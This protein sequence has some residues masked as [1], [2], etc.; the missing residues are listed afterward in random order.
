M[1]PTPPTAVICA[2][3]TLGLVLDELATSAG[4]EVTALVSRGVD[5]AVEAA[6][7]RGEPFEDQAPGLGRD[8]GSVVTDRHHVGHR[9]RLAAR[10]H[11][12]PD[13]LALL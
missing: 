11:D 8:A 6:L 2:D 13:D 7:Q 3:A 5:A 4:L 1:R 9:V 10:E 12:R